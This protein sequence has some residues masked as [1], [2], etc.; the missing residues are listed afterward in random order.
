MTDNKQK[1]VVG[2]REWLT[3]PSLGIDAIKAKIDTGARSSAIHAYSIETELIEGREFAIFQVHPMQDDLSNSITCRA[4]IVDR[5]IVRDSG[6]HEEERLF[7]STTVEFLGKHWE[8]EFSLTNR[9]NMAFRMLLGRTS[10]VGGGLI[11]DPALSFTQGEELAAKK[12]TA[13]KESQL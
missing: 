1:Y 9:E 8:A 2:W 6:G 4:P 3:L 10:L 7:I 11:V 5:R 13:S 12:P